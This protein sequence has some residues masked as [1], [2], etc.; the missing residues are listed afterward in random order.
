[1]LRKGISKRQNFTTFRKN[2]QGYLKTQIY[3]KRYF[4]Y[5]GTS[6]WLSDE[7]TGK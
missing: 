1:M 2:I 7:F 3:L 4:V 5:F 6:K